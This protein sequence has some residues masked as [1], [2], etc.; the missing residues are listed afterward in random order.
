MSWISINTDGIGKAY[1]RGSRSTNVS[2]EPAEKRGSRAICRGER[3]HSRAY[4]P[5]DFLSLTK[6]CFRLFRN[7]EVRD[8]AIV[9]VACHPSAGLNIRIDETQRP[10]FGDQIDSSAKRLCKSSR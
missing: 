4:L 3:L 1:Q 9:S 2:T 5:K 6:P 10:R 7:F 8:V